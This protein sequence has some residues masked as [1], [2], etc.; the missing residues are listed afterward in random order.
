MEAAGAL[1]TAGAVTGAIEPGDPGSSGEG[2]CLNCG[3]SLNGG[4]YCSNCGQAAQPHRTLGGLVSEFLSS[5]YN[6]DTKAWRT[7]PRLLFRPGT[8]TREYVYGKR[9]RYISP[10]AA[11]LLSIFLMFFAFSTIETP[12]LNNMGEYNAEDLAEAREELAQAQAELERARTNPD[13]DQPEGLEVRLAENSVRLAQAGVERT[14]R[15]IAQQAAREAAARQQ[16]AQAAN[17]P[18]AS[19]PE[20]AATAPESAATGPAPAAAAPEPA[21]SV[22]EPPDTSDDGLNVGMS[23]SGEPISEGSSWQD[24]V[25]AAVDRGDVKVNMGHP[26]LNAR[27]LQSLRN[28]DLALYQIQDAAAKFSFLL[29]PLSLPF[30]ALLFLWKRG[31]T[32]YDHMAYALYALAFAALLFSTVVLLG[33]VPWLTWAA[34]WL[35]LAL[36]VHTY[37]HIGGAYALGWFSALWRTFFMLI[38]AV[39]VACIFFTLAIILGLAG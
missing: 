32:L 19:T 3:T 10:L 26:A 34:G 23:I 38:F 27:A 5:L 1:A 13:P 18:P 22:P 11:F 12:D 21:A 15:I 16:A 17:A 9:A 31:V 25:R 7:L 39:I 14:E 2:P 24:Q 20:P 37:F 8:L 6:F 4:R 35:L 28:P 36:P 29:A 33:N 30:I